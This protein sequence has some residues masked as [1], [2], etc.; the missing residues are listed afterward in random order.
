MNP[1][2]M[3]S[4][5]D[6]FFPIFSSDST[7]MD[8]IN[9]PYHDAYDEGLIDDYEIIKYLLE[10]GNQPQEGLDGFIEALFKSN[11][12]IELFADDR[13]RNIFELFKK[14]GAIPTISPIYINRS[15]W[16]DDEYVTEICSDKNTDLVNDYLSDDY[17]H[18]LRVVILETCIKVFPEIDFKN[19]INWTKIDNRPYE[20][21]L[22]SQL[23]EETRMKFLMELEYENHEKK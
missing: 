17:N 20:R 23:S 10:I 22:F 13:G 21:S 6:E 2:H 5:W 3:F 7:G 12:G 14:Y 8:R 15:D 18:D 16:M 1:S 4:T 19:G 9:H 11:Y